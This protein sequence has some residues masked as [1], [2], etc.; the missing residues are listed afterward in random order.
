M[1]CLK[2][3]TLQVDALWSF[4]ALIRCRL[5]S[6]RQNCGTRLRCRQKCT[7][8]FS[9]MGGGTTECTGGPQ[10]Q[11]EGDSCRAICNPLNFRLRGDAKAYCKGGAWRNQREVRGSR[12]AEARCVSVGKYSIDQF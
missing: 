4:L 1:H 2:S 7:E 12:L 3:L 8:E 9:V 6:N 5:E 11:F 10:G